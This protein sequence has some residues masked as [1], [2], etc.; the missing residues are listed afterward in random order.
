MASIKQVLAIGAAAAMTIAVTSCSAGEEPAQVLRLG[1]APADTVEDTFNQWSYVMERLEA[2]TGYK[3]E[4]FEAT[5]IA[6][7][8]EGAIAGDLDI[9]HFGAFPHLIAHQNGAEISTVGA[10]A[11]TPA[12]LNNASVAVVRNDSPVKELQELK[13]QDICFTSPTSTTG[14]LF[15][16]KAF[17][18]LGID[19][20]ADVNPIFIGDHG[21]AI[22]TMWNSECA[23][24]FTYRDYAERIAYDENPDIPAGGLRVI[25]SEEVPEGGTAISTKLPKETQDTLRAALLKINGTAELEAGNCPAELIVDPEDGSGQYCGIWPGKR[26]GLVEKDDTYWEPMREVCEATNAPACAR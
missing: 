11:S 7:I 18:D 17:I 6:A 25:W 12:G 3:I 8:V 20:E 22:G 5:D 2:E 9:V 10:I 4:L 1:V 23:A 21:S 19:P 16:A 24:A 14:Y 13:G 26:W 15:G